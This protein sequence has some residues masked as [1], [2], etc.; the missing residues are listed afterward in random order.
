MDWHSSR[1]VLARAHRCAA[2]EQRV[3]NPGSRVSVRRARLSGKRISVA[4]RRRRAAKRLQRILFATVDRQF[5][6][7]NWP[8]GSQFARVKMES[9]DANHSSIELRIES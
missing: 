4:L 7:V 1:A 2:L 9:L 3:V 5:A 6:R 8:R